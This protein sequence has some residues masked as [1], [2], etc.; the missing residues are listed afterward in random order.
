MVWDSVLNELTEKRDELRRAADKVYIVNAGVVNHGKSSLFNSLLGEGEVFRERGSRETAVSQI[1]AYCQNAYFV[2]TPGLNADEHNEAEICGIY[3][4]AGFILFVHNSK[5]GELQRQEIE[6]LQIMA[7]AVGADYFWKHVVL[8]LTFAE[9]LDSEQTTELQTKIE[10][11]VFRQFKKNIRVFSVSN[12][13]FDEAR[14]GS[15]LERKSLDLERSGIPE[16]QKYLTSH[17]AQWQREHTRLQEEKFRKA[18]QSAL[19]KINLQRD[20]ICLKID[21]RKAEFCK[22]DSLDAAAVRSR[23]QKL[24]DDIRNYEEELRKSDSVLRKINDMRLQ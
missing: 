17:I 23:E 11:T 20:G 1:E 10:K 14:L 8:V 6:H 4:K 24:Q 12:S 15:D 19:S 16:L 9:D 21:R 5:T 22:A 13:C 18:R 2:D 7:D 3:E